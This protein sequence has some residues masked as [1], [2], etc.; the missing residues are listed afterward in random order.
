MSRKKPDPALRK[1][2]QR[3]LMLAAAVITLLLVIMVVGS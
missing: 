1:R 3:V 2:D